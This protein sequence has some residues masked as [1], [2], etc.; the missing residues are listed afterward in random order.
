MRAEPTRLPEGVRPLL[1]VELYRDP[2]GN[3]FAGVQRDEGGGMSSSWTSTYTTPA[4][5]FMAAYLLASPNAPKRHPAR[6]T[7]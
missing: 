2:N 7:L 5:A 6:D 3:W 1:I 4:E